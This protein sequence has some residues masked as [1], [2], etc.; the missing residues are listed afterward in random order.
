MY[1]TGTRRVFT[2]DLR[3]SKGLSSFPTSATRTGD[4]KE[5]LTENTESILNYAKVLLSLLFN[6]EVHKLNVA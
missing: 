5:I 4:K 2:A 6:C 3:L 1:V